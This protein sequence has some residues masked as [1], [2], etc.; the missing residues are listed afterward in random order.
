[1]PCL[2]PNEDR[3]VKSLCYREGIHCP[4]QLNAR[5]YNLELAS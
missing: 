1:M 2:F 4:L 3:T 5:T